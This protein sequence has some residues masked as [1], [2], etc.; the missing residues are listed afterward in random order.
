MGKVTKVNRYFLWLLLALNITT[1]PFSEES[2]SD[3]MIKEYKAT[4]YALGAVPVAELDRKWWGDDAG[5]TLYFKGERVDVNGWVASDRIRKGNF[6]T[7][8][9]KERAQ[10]AKKKPLTFAQY[11]SL[12]DIEGYR[13]NKEPL[14]YAIMAI[15]LDNMLMEGVKVENPDDII[16]VYEAG[17]GLEERALR[18][19]KGRLNSERA[20]QLYQKHRDAHLLA[21]FP[22]PRPDSAHKYSVRRFPGCLTGLAD[23]N[24]C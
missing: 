8:A 24:V 19:L 21:V 15:A 14:Q 13:K 7:N 20:M 11:V 5:N 2:E 17:I 18:L 16:K 4:L 10:L 12:I 3:D 9:E 1:Y 6:L 22:V 23:Q